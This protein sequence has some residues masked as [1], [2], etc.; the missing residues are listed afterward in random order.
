ME[1]GWLGVVDCVL[2]FALTPGLSRRE[3][4]WEAV[5]EVRLGVHL[6]LGCRFSRDAV[7]V[8]GWG[9][10]GDG[11]AEGNW[12]LKRAV[13]REK[14]APGGEGAGWGAGGTLKN[15]GRGQ[16][17]SKGTSFS[18]VGSAGASPS[19]FAFGSS[20]EGRGQALFAPRTSQNEPVPSGSSHHQ[21]SKMPRFWRIAAEGVE[22][23]R[24]SGAF[25]ET[26]LS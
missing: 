5:R 17:S 15:S 23:P 25:V 4:E 24:L 6:R 12:P 10:G 2:W 18:G 22:L 13:R 14:A 8:F 20:S 26:E 16:V 3:R 7:L 21:P 11:A 19:W 9:R 1:C